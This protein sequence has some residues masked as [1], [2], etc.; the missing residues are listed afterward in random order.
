MEEKIDIS[1]SPK[2]KKMLIIIMVALVFGLLTVFAIYKYLTPKR[3]TVWLFNAD[4][5]AGTALTEDM[6]Y[7]V[8]AD[9]TIVVAG[10]SAQ[11]SSQFVTGSEKTAIVNSGDSLRID[12]SAGMPL[13]RGI[14][15]VNG[16]TAVEMN[17]DPSKVCVTVPCTSVTGITDELAKGS[18]VNIYATGYADGVGTTT[19]LIFQGMKVA[20]TAKKEGAI[21][22]ITL[23]VTVEESLKLINFQNSG[24]L[25]FGLVDTTGYQYVEEDKSY[26]SSIARKNVS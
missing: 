1:Q 14:L 22:A 11:T 23:E 24:N 26:T 8:Q 18:R 15:S 13:T 6:L 4:Y 12:V 3:T 2:N 25:Y 9:S 16:G 21:Q 20:N 19:T 5:K 10:A 17:M 7:A